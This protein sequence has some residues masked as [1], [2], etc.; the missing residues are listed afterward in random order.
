MGYYFGGNALRGFFIKAVYNFDYYSAKS[1]YAS[2][3][4]GESTLG[5]IFGSQ[6]ILSREGGFT[7]AWGSA[8]DSPPA[9]TIDRCRSSPPFPGSPRSAAIRIVPASAS[10]RAR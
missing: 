8:S 10:T 5:A 7:L 4:Y 6:T 1:D 3:S 2:T 9:C